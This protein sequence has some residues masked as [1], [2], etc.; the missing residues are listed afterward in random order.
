LKRVKNVK[1][2]RR[3]SERGEKWDEVEREENG[4]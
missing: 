4:E 2:R 3:S 1:R